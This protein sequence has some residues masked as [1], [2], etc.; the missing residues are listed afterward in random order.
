MKIPTIENKAVKNG[1]L[2]LAG[3]VLPLI[4]I[5]DAYFILLLCTTGIAV[6]VVSG[7]DVLFG[8]SGQ[9]SLGHA[10]FY[11][12]G[13]YTSAILCKFFSLP[14][15]F[16]MFVGALVATLIAVCLALPAVKLVH[17][18]LALV[19]ISF[20][21]LTYL[22]VAN[23]KQLTD[24]YSGMNFI[25]KP[26]LGF[27]TFESNLSY[28][29]LIYFFLLVL[30]AVKSRLMDSRTGRAFIAIRENA[31]AANGMG[32]NVV[33]YK[34]MAFAVSAFYAGFAGA[35]YA[36]LVGFISPE[37]FE[38]NQSVI[39]LTMLLFGGMGNLWGSVVGAAALTFVAEILQKL[40]SY[41]MLAYGV[42]LLVIIV[43]IPGGLTQ[44]FNVLAYLKG[45]FKK[46]KSNAQ[47]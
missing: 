46:E 4:F 42:F 18:F 27:F 13:A 21:Q 2:A 20:G 47:T 17:H 5:G 33:K 35:L 36:H 40:G 1:L 8:Y 25:P 38:M 41:Q 45:G 39:F 44:G 3:A 16:T 12:I 34:V 14:P 43:F 11:C 22:F 32:V 19:T 30:L 28:F 9:I 23:A 6:I 10:S 24:G 26:S 15:I 37:S 29:Y 7:L 31:H